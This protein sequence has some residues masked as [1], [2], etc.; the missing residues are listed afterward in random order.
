MKPEPTARYLA[1]QAL[2]RVARGERLEEALNNSLQGFSPEPRERALAWELAYGVCRWQNLLDH[3]LAAF[4]KKPLA[5]L[6]PEVL[7][8]LRLGAYQIL[9]LERIPDRAAVHATVE[10]ASRNLPKWKSGFVNAVLR[11][12]ARDRG[13]VRLPGRG[14]D[15]AGY[16]ALAQSHPR[17]LVERWLG[18]LG[19]KG[20]EALLEADNRRA[21][22]CIRVNRLVAEPGQILD[23]LRE[24]GLEARPGEY[25]PQAVLAPGGSVALL[26]EVLGREGPAL[27]TAQSEAAQAVAP[28]AAP[29]PGQRILDLCAGVGGKSLHLAELSGDKAS[30]TS[31]E[32]SAPRVAAGK[33]AVRRAGLSSIRYLQGDALKMGPAELGAGLFDT[34]LID[35]PCT[36]S[37]VLA[38]RPDIRWRLKPDDPARTARIQDRLLEAGAR[39]T[40]PGGTLVYATC[41]LFRE[42]NQDRVGAFLARR[43]EFT[44]DDPAPLLPA[45]LLPLLNKEGLLA[46]SPGEQGLDGFFGARMVKSPKQTVE[47]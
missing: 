23:R 43:P 45:P 8:L 37:G 1:W 39:L 40:A 19:P 41:S 18:E 44:L 2:D 14:K 13:R 22:M 16:L 24:A 17:W 26:E 5:R 27:F 30:I 20:A 9:K 34:V 12:L 46:T 6:S 33:K 32:I 31:L 11:A 7:T 36:G 10:A 29:C 47:E 4:S 25:G 21:G 28:L 35:A 42:E 3:H 38:G 15:L